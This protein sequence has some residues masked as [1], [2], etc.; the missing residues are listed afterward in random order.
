MKLGVLVK[1][2]TQQSAASSATAVKIDDDELVLALGFGHGLF[3]RSLEPVLGRSGG[4]ENEDTRK[5]EGFLHGGL[6]P[7]L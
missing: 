4:G 6:L 3:Q 2:L 5:E 7:R 1:L